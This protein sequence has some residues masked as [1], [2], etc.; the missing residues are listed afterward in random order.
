MRSQFAAQLIFTGKVIFPQQSKYLIFGVFSDQRFRKNTSLGRETLLF[1]VFGRVLRICAV[2]FKSKIEVLFRFPRTRW[3]LRQA[4][5]WVSIPGGMGG[6]GEYIPPN[7][8]GGGDGLYNHPPPNN[9]PSKKKKIKR[10][11]SDESPMRVVN[12]VMLFPFTLFK[13]HVIVSLLV[14]CHSFYFLIFPKTF[15]IFGERLLCHNLFL[16]Y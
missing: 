12:V 5:P 4:A 7:I 2:F 16:F 8:S 9:S 13:I 1:H 11:I 3:R 10:K 15:F 14:F 6:G